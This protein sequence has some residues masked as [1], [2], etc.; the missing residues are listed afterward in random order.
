[1][2]RLEVERVDP[3]Q[4]RA[5]DDQRE[6]HHPGVEQNALDEAMP[7]R[8]DDRRRQE[9]DQHADHETARG[10]TVKKPSAILQS[11]RK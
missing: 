8:A 7:E 3:E 6:A 5:A 4:Y 2:D 10:R 11:F 1:M 9:R